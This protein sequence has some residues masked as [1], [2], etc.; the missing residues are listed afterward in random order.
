MKAEIEY[1]LKKEKYFTAMGL[2]KNLS[3]LIAL[4]LNIFSRLKLLPRNV[5][6]VYA[7]K[8]N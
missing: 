4:I 1:G 6:T 2:P 7:T 8:R 3:I 5:F